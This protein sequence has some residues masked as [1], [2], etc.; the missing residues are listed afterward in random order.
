MFENTVPLEAEPAS[1]QDG[2]A[3]IPLNAPD[4]PFIA[5]TDEECRNNGLTLQRALVVRL[6]V[7]DLKRG[8]YSIGRLREKY[9]G[10][11]NYKPYPWMTIEEFAI[12]LETATQAMVCDNPIDPRFEIA[13]YLA[14]NLML[15]ETIYEMLDDPAN[16]AKPRTMV[17]LIKVLNTLKKERLDF[18]RQFGIELAQQA[19]DP[20]KPSLLPPGAVPVT[21]LLAEGAQVLERTTVPVE[22]A[23]IL[24]SGDIASDGRSRSTERD[25]E[26]KQDTIHTASLIS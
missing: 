21:D 25:L 5:L 2:E 24:T 16:K 8:L 13:G 4:D 23:G 22:F 15:Q 6:L 19:T 3:V 14:S 11:H 20:T 9:L 1:I 17:E 26:D 12:L 7:E 18:M 10:S